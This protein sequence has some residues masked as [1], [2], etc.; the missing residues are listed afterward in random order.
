MRRDRGR[1]RRMGGTKKGTCKTGGRKEETLSGRKLDDH[2]LS[3]RRCE[4]TPAVVGHGDER[5][6]STSQLGRVLGHCH[7]ADHW[8][9]FEA[10]WPVNERTVECRWRRSLAVER[11]IARQGSVAE[12]TAA[13]QTALVDHQIR[14]RLFVPHCPIPP[15]RRQHTPSPC[16]SSWACSPFFQPSSP[17][18]YCA[19]NEVWV[20]R[21]KKKNDEPERKRKD[22]AQAGSG[23]ACRVA[24]A[25][26]AVPKRATRGNA[27]RN[28]V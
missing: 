6:G 15:R 25:G 26:A 8:R 3:A 5:R 19:L 18:S 16:R 24:I 10:Q 14:A 2:E 23:D 11:R 17:R 20:P 9:E 22:G 21:A 13:A 27:P 1:W 4:K 7:V 12:R 28:G